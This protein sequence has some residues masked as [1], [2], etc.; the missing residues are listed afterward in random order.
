MLNL[1]MIMMMSDT[2]V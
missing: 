1:S 2:L